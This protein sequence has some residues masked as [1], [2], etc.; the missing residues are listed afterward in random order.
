MPDL[1]PRWRPPRLRCRITREQAHYH[2]QSWKSIR[3]AVLVRDACTCRS[4][5]AVVAG[6]AAHVDH[7]TPLEEGGSDAL[8]N[9]QVLCMSCH[10]RKSVSEQR[11]RGRLG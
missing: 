10:G 3:S 7:V 1:I 9:L 5:G 8:M 6:K 2:T 11:R 4:C